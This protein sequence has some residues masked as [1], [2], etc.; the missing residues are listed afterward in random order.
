MNDQRDH[1]FDSLPGASSE[2]QRVSP[3]AASGRDYGEMEWSDLFASLRAQRRMIASIVLATTTFAVLYAFL[4]TQWYTADTLIAPTDT[5]GSAKAAQLASLGGLASLA[6]ISLSKDNGKDV[7]IA[8]LTSRALIEALIRDENL[9]PV[10]FAR[11]WDAEKGDWKSHDPE[12][13]PTVLDGYVYFS[14]KILK[15]EEDRRKGLVTV[16]VKWKS[17]EL[18]AHWVNE[19]VKRADELLR[20]RAVDESE[21]NLVF[22]QQ[23]E[24][25]TSIVP[26]KQAAYVLMESELRKAMMA[27]SGDHY[28]FLM[29]DPAVVPEKRSWPKRGVIILA[30]LL[31]G[32]LFSV[33]AALF[34]GIQ[35]L[36]KS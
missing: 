29:V 12:K 1:R 8:E 13:V 22:L 17:P 20:K 11:R 10:L 27:K 2:H 30:G 35:S 23:Q 21:H 33:V 3:S 18:A 25:E 4:S 31:L 14:K 16:S 9:L 19:L 7:A 5:S 34:R 6:G 26:L 24:R 15:V 36:D 32:M 28:A